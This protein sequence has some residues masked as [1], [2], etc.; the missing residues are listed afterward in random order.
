MENKG[1]CG[2][3]H[4]EGKWCMILS[5]NICSYKKCP[6]FKSQLKFER[7]NNTDFLYESYLKG[8]ISEE[9][10]IYLCETYYSRKKIKL[11]CQKRKNKKGA[12]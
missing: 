12:V 2:Y 8:N 11:P 4:E 3:M 5:E 7:D 9:R 6:F 10:Y 1:K